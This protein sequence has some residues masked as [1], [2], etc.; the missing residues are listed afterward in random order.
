MEKK[1]FFVGMLV[2]GSVWGFSE[3][4][5]G[6]ILR[7]ANLPAGAIMTGIVAVGVLSLSRI[8]FRQ[9][10]MQLGIGLI[11]GTLRLFNPFGACFICSAI[12]IAAEGALFEWIVGALPLHLREL[13][14][15]KMQISFG[16]IGA[17]AIYVGGYIITQIMT[18]LISTAGFDVKNLVV[19]IPSILASGLLAALLGGF[20]VSVVVSVQKIHK[21]LTATLYYP[22]LIGISILCWIGILLNYYMYFTF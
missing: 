12:A 19:F 5:L 9:R 14:T 22:T 4:I 21:P 1:K 18:P 11:A 16:I 10:G 17:Y 15:K 8:L 20:T 6:S 3:C 2:F 7:D 13:T